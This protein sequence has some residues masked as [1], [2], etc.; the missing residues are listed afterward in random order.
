MANEQVIWFW[1]KSRKNPDA[2]LSRILG[3]DHT[4]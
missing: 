2:K 4:E 1:W 3:A